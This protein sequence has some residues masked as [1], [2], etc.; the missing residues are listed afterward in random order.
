M[1]N[2]LTCRHRLGRHNHIK[3]YIMD[4]VMDIFWEYGHFIK[5]L[6][7]H[8]WPSSGALQNLS[9]SIKRNFNPAQAR[10]SINTRIFQIL[11]STVF[12]RWSF[13]FCF[14]VR[15]AVP[16][17][18]VRRGGAWFAPTLS[19]RRPVR[20]DFRPRFKRLAANC[21]TFKTAVKS[22]MARRAQLWHKLCHYLFCCRT[23][24]M[25]Y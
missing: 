23:M 20:C 25:Y 19:T 3:W 22:S 5:C 8:I 16:S 18:C 4:D 9:L 7:F 2:F 1:R 11:V 12:D 15:L 21:S 10:P 6:Y 24:T 13:G 14:C 17:S